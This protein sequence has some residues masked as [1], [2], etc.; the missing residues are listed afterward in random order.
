M[1]GYM[2][3]KCIAIPMKAAKSI[4]LGAMRG[5]RPEAEKVVG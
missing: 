4:A 3:K 1:M 2:E 5:R